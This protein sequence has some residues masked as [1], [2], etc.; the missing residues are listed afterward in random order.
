MLKGVLIITHDMQY[1]MNPERVEWFC[2]LKLLKNEG[3]KVFVIAPY[4]TTNFDEKKWQDFKKSVE[5]ESD[6]F[7]FFPKKKSINNL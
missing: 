4:G 5:K 1:K 6:G 7:Y 2:L 3:L